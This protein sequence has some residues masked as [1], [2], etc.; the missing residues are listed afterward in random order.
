MTTIERPSSEKPWLDYRAV[1]RWHFY[2]GLFSIP[3]IVVLAVTGAIY[4]FKPQVEA[5]LDHPYDHL[6]L[7]GYS[8]SAEA[9]VTAALAAVP[10]AKLFAYEVPISPDA[11][12]RVLV[13]RDNDQIRVYVHPETLDILKIIREE[14]QFMRIMSK[15]HGELL[16]GNIGSAIVEL[17]ASWAIIMIVTGLYLWWP[18]TR[19]GLGGIVYP[20]LAR[21]SRMFWRDWHAVIG[22]WISSLT[23]FLLLTGLPWAKVWGEYFKEVR[24]LT[25]T[26][27][28]QDWMVGAARSDE[29][30]AASMEHLNHSTTSSEQSGDAEALPDYSEIDRL[31]DIVRPLNLAPPVLISP[32]VKST[33]NWT[34]KSDSQNR[35]LR[36]NLVLDGT[37]STVLNRKDF[38]DRH[39]LDRIVGVGIAAHEGQLFGWPNQALGVLTAGGLLLLVT[40]SVVMWWRRRPHGMLGTPETVY[41]SRLSWGLGILILSFGLYLPLFAASLILVLLVERFILRR[42]PGASH[43]LGLRG[44][45]EL[46]SRQLRHAKPTEE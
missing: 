37:T 42:I 36:V 35:P 13:K 22:F 16:L 20:R 32:P 33:A 6:T 25:G 30:K 28:Q 10:G 14:D 5:W 11:A 1:W 8:S 4:L 2:A 7:T 24:Q 46:M 15:L 23:L 19:R 3:F 18:R 44:V 26:A 9:H 39:L 38:Q 29:T 40:S 21:G 45:S 31:V 43:W 27:A 41:P 12:A 34:A 17:A